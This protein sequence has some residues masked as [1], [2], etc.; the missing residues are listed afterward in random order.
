MAQG[1]GTHTPSWALTHVCT[2][3]H[4]C[5]RPDHRKACCS[6]SL[7]RPCSV[8]SP[9]PQ[10]K[11]RLVVRKERSP[12]CSEDHHSGGHWGPE[13]SEEVC[14]AYQSGTG[15][16]RKKG[17][18]QGSPTSP[19]HQWC[20]THPWAE[21][22]ICKGNGVLGTVAGIPQEETRPSGTDGAS[23]RPVTHTW[24]HHESPSERTWGSTGR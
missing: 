19:L 18:L 16:K 9:P 17:G 11:L 7:V 21:P 4:L 3:P 22:R 10:K 20:P 13:K 6:G 12:T 5:A 2:P 8:P 24:K 15:A 23:P 14:W 1:Y